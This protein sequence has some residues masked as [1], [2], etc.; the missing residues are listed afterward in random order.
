MTSKKNIM[1][2]YNVTRVVMSVLLIFAVYILLEVY[3]MQNSPEYAMRYYFAFPAMVEN[4]LGGIFVY[5]LFG[6]I[7]IKI[8]RG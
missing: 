4:V 5:A 7:F 3:H 8:N 2:F 1:F 6:L